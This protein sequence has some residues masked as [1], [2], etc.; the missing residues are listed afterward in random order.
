MK[1]ICLYFNFNLCKPIP[2]ALYNRVWNAYENDNFW[3]SDV[4]VELENYLGTK[5]YKIDRAIYEEKMEKRLEDNKI[6]IWLLMIDS[7]FDNEPYVYVYG[8][9]RDEDTAE[10]NKHE[11][12]AK[13]QDAKFW[14]EELEVE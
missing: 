13:Y 11:A 9:Y 4:Q 3:Q 5:V 1:T 8:A 10:A 2:E 7:G 14:I 12:E 6:K